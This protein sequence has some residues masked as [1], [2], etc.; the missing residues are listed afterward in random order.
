MSNP[1]LLSSAAFWAAQ[2][3]GHAQLGDRRRTARLVTVTTALAQNPN[4][5]LPGTFTD[6]VDLR[7]AYR[8]FAEGDVTH[9]AILAPHT[10]RVAQACQTAGQY[11]L[12]EDT[13]TLSFNTHVATADLGPVNDQ[14]GRGFLVH[15]TLA[16]R[17]TDWNP[18][19]VPTVK[20]EGL[21]GQQCWSRPNS[22][23]N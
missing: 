22:H 6:W 23:R 12:V 21:A 20:V 17:V 3:M 14:G 11:L 10:Q 16:L 7:A 18:D 15:N 9:A 13:T 8:L 5:T 2:E 1:D 19:Q 4:G